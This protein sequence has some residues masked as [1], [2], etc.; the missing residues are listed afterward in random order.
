VA[1]I[2]DKS[3]TKIAVW[4]YLLRHVSEQLENAAPPATIETGDD[5][6]N[7]LCLYEFLPDCGV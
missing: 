5:V 1:Q 6:V 7:S 2:E 3:K 4:S